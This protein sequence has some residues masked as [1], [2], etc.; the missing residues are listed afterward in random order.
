[1]AVACRASSASTPVR[2]W[3][4]RLDRAAQRIDAGE[5]VQSA[6]RKARVMN[7]REAS[8]LALA[9][10]HQSLSWALREIAESAMRR[11]FERAS[12]LTQIAVVVLVLLTAAYVCLVAVAVMSTLAEWVMKSVPHQ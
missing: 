10:N 6:L 7:R 9:N 12:V 8:T 5:P 1:M 4:R 2:K 11:T 3:S